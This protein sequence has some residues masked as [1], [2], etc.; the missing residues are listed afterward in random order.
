M[1]SAANPRCRSARA[2]PRPA[3][4]APTM[5]SAQIR[6][7][8][9]SRLPG[10]LRGRIDVLVRAED[11]PRVIG[12]L[13]GGQTRVVLPVGSSYAVGPSSPRLLTYTDSSRC[14]RIDS[15]SDVV[16]STLLCV[17]AG[18]DHCDRI[19]KSCC[20]ARCAN[21]VA[22]L[23]TRLAA[24]CIRCSPTLL[25][26]EGIWGGIPAGSRWRRRSGG[27]AS[28]TSSS[29][30]SARRESLVKSPCSTG[31]GNGWITSST[32]A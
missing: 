9:S 7:L 20:A 18:S 24:P 27:A 8:P 4:P 17:S 5:R 11:V 25:T 19:R 28:R 30:Q 14:G 22:V 1:T 16:H 3:I 32:G 2:V 21:A 6:H 13:D 26:D 31:Y 23:G 29:A 12:S 15:N 10:G